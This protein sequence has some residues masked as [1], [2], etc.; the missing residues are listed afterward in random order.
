M[1]ADLRAVR[2]ALFG[3]A[4]TRNASLVRTAVFIQVL[5]SSVFKEDVFATDPRVTYEPDG[6][7]VFSAGILE[8]Y[9]L[10][11]II[12][13]LAFINNPSGTFFTGYNRYRDMWQQSQDQF[14]R[15]ASVLL[16]AA[17]RTERAAT[18]TE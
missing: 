6:S 9:N 14:D 16:V 8:E 10:T 2:R 13:S 4:P 11:D 5:H 3:E 7:E 18:G 1:S 15:L 12:N 17:S